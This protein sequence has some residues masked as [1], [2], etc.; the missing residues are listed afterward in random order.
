MASVK[1]AIEESVKA[2]VRG[3]HSHS[4]ANPDVTIP[5]K[6]VDWLQNDKSVIASFEAQLGKRPDKWNDDGPQ[7]CMAAFHAGSLA[8]FYAYAND[9]KVVTDDNAKKALAHIKKACDVSVGIR[10][11][12]C[13]WWPFPNSTKS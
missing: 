1:E 2:F 7:V 6:V 10:Y 9:P 4:P 13:P 11:V 5:D 12:Y 8:A 3:V